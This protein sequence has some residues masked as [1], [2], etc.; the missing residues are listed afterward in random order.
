[1]AD[2]SPKSYADILAAEQQLMRQR[3]MQAQ[4]NAEGNGIVSNSVQLQQLVAQRQ[5]NINAIANSGGNIAALYAAQG[6]SKSAVPS[7]FLTGNPSYAPVGAGTLPFSGT[8]S[9]GSDAAAMGGVTNAQVIQNAITNQ[10]AKYYGG[11][12]DPQVFTGMVPMGGM[13]GQA[14]NV[15]QYQSLSQLANSWYGLDQATRDKFSA[16][17]AKAGYK[18]E[19]FSDADLGNLWGS[20]AGMAAAYNANGKQ[21]SLWD[22]L[23]LDAQ[24]HQTAK[25]ITT[26]NTSTSYQLSDLAD[27]HALFMQA[28]QSLLGRAPTTS[29]TKAFQKQ[30]N[31]YQRANPTKT[32]TTQTT[33]AS[34][35]TSSS[36]TT[37]GGT[38]AAAESDMA[39]QAAQQNPEYGAYQAATTYFNSLLNAIGHM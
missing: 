39:Q 25:P 31:A 20:Y 2:N 14:T 36:S 35:N 24:H 29:E 7:S 16:L 28:A 37:S 6:G 5:S 1:M 19:T 38:T 13:G 15:P 22:V 9:L 4:Y 27:T 10:A 21:M 32:T 18:I 30:L 34:G 17:A 8:G 11:S 23:N 33:D 12:D 3:Q 26:T